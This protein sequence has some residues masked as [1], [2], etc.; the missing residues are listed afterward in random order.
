MNDYTFLTLLLN[1]NTQRVRQIKKL[2]KAVETRD[3]IIKQL[4]EANSLYQVEIIDL[5]YEHEILATNNEFL[6]DSVARL[7]SAIR[8]KKIKI[9]RDNN[10]MFVTDLIDQLAT[11]QNQRSYDKDD[12]EYCEYFNSRH[13]ALCPIFKFL[14]DFINHTEH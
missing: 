10:E 2:L 13:C 5:D 6:T 14:D 7:Y 12:R 11:C 1:N 8:E 3:A 4:L 9:I